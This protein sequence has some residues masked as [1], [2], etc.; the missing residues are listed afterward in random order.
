M[1]HL[2]QPVCLCLPRL[3]WSFILPIAGGTSFG[4]HLVRDLDLETPCIC[5]KGKKRCKCS[6]TPD[7]DSFWLF[8]RYSMGWRCGLHADWTELNDC[9]DEAMD[10]T[11]GISSIQS[12]SSHRRYFYITLLRN[13]V[14]RFLSEWRH[15]Q[16][17]AT[18]KSSEFF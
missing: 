10:E 5:K 3:I 2:D 4:R 9:V 14:L 1:I 6:R 12:N 11:E 15:V 17:G 7:E 18:W 16:R 13:P 8:S